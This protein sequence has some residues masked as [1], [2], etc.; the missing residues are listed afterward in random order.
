MKKLL[1]LLLAMITVLGMFAGCGEEKKPS[2][3]NNNPIQIIIPDQEEEERTYDTIVQEAVATVAEA[4]FARRTYIQYE[5]NP[6]IKS[7]GQLRADRHKYSPEDATSQFTT[8]SNC[9]TFTFDVYKEALDLD[10]VAWT[11]SRLQAAKDMHVLTSES[12]LTTTE[13]KDEWR[14]KITDL[15][16]PGDIVSYLK[17]NWGHAM[18]YIG[19]DEVIHCSSNGGVGGS[20][21]MATNTEVLDPAGGIYRVNV[22]EILTGKHALVDMDKFC[23]VRPTLRHPDA[24]PTEKT[25]NRIENLKDIYVEK[26]S[27][28]AVGMTAAQGDEVTFTFVLKN[29]RKSEATVVINDTVPTNTTYVSGADSVDGNTLK[30]TVNIPVGGKTQ[31]SYT[32]KVNDNAKT[33]DKIAST[34]YVGGVDVR[35][36]DIYVGGSLTAAEQQKI[37]D[38]AAKI[39]GDSVTGTALAKKIYS[40]A[41]IACDIGT[42]QEIISSIFKST[43]RAAGHFELNTGSPYMKMLAPTMYGGYLVYVNEGLYDGNRTKAPM[44][45]QLM[46]GDIIVCKEGATYNVWLFVG[47]NKAMSLNKGKVGV[48]DLIGTR[49]A[50]FSTIG[51]DQF[52]IVRPAM[53]K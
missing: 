20:Y 51:H 49:D 1:A 25:L 33:G 14:Q 47:Q 52:V 43:S 34:A 11:C 22:S 5:D 15:L 31:V 4:Y 16:Q 50:L 44:I 41:G 6:L 12:K 32:V 21:N 10:I 18:L 2:S 30:W 42:E 37:F 46:A 13:E 39:S 40:A 7:G 27:S 45:T 28:H 3:E 24:Q 53:A 48:L 38:E 9:A 29:S 19:H 8:Y 36:R 17:D 26:I 35:C 23:I